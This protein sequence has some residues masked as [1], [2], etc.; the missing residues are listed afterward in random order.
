MRV[1]GNEQLTTQEISERLSD[2]PKSSIYRHLKLLLA[3]DLVGIAE[4]RLINGIQEKVYQLLQPPSLGPSDVAMLTAEEH[5]QYFTTYALM[6]IEGFA[7][8]VTETESEQGSIDMVSDRVGYREVAFY[9]T[10]LELDVAVGA[11]N[12]ALLPLVQN[13]P[14]NGRRLYKFATILHPQKIQK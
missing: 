5:I 6:L 7:A 10:P 1:L 11:M 8:Y 13:E 12:Q 14:S 4:T 9:A 3:G 2:V